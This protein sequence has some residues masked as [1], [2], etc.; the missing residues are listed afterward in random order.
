LVASGFAALQLD[1]Y[2]GLTPSSP[3]PGTNITAWADQS[4]NHNNGTKAGV[5][6]ITYQVDG[7]GKPYLQ[8]PATNATFNL[9]SNLSASHTQTFAFAYDSN[10]AFGNAIEVILAS[11]IVNEYIT[12]NFSSD[13]GACYYNDGTG[14]KKIGTIPAGKHYNVIVVDAVNA[15]LYVDGTPQTPTAIVTA[16]NVWSNTCIGGKQG[17]PTSFPLLS[18]RISAI[19]VAA[20]A[21]NTAARVT[22]FDTYCTAAFG[23]H[24]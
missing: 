10:G 23:A 14:A 5:N 13:P 11:D 15:T 18:G 9:G 8:Y 20:D 17:D 24:S 16:T 1:A 6:N 19:Y 3:S 12:V 4:T 21:L 7:Y 2:L 22:A